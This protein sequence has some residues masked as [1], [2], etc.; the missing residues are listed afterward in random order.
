MHRLVE[1][2]M[3]R[4]VEP[5]SW[6]KEEKCPL[7]RWKR[8]TREIGHNASFGGTPMAVSR[9]KGG[10]KKKKSAGG[11]RMLLVI[12][13]RPYASP[14]TRWC[15]MSFADAMLCSQNDEKKKRRKVKEKKETLKGE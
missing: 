5:V 7:G 6:R 3:K 10:G 9:E 2:G 12:L 11:G 13:P 8:R 14:K 4:L 15:A 1:P